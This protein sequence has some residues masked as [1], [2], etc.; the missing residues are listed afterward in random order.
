MKLNPVYEPKTLNPSK[1]YLIDSTQY[2]YLRIEGTG[3]HIKYVFS[4]LPNQ[5]KTSD[6]SLNNTKLTIKC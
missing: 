6:I 5:R 1:V 4:P 2:R 3:K